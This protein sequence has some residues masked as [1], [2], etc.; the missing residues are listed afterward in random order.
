MKQTFIQLWALYV[1]VFTN[2]LPD[3]SLIQRFRGWLYGHKKKKRGKNFQVSSNVRFTFLNNISVGRDVF[4]GCDTTVLATNP[5][6]LEDEVMLAHKVM[7]VTGNHTLK[8]GSY[9]FGEPKRAAVVIKKGSWVG[10][11]CTVLPGVTIGSGT[12]VGANSVVTKDIPD[13]CI[14]GGVPACVIRHIGSDELQ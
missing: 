9:R 1:R 14:V 6:V 8:D 4:I 2:G 7:I 3:A 13:D 11:L 10:A 12:V 5:V